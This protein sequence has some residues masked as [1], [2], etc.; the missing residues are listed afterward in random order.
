MAWQ[1]LSFF[2]SVLMGQIIFEPGRAPGSLHESVKRQMR[3][4]GIFA[5][6]FKSLKREFFR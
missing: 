5:Q 4:G 6:T 2:R 1:A 3:D